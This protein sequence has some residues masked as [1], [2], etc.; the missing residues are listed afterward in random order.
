MTL[1]HSFPTTSRDDLMAEQQYRLAR[2]LLDARL[3]S[4]HPDTLKSTNNLALSYTA[5][6]RHAEAPEAVP[7]DAGG[8]GGDA[9]PR[10]PRHAHEPEQPRRE[11]RRPGA[12]R[13]RR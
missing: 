5:L 2:T 10:P 6:G 12:T 8:P 7:G 1:G 3:G 13:R 9:G 11:L 4:D